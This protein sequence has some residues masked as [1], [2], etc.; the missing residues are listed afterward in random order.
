MNPALNQIMTSNPLAV[1]DDSPLSA[2]YHR[3]KREVVR[4]L[5]VVDWNG[6][7]VGIISDRDFQRA[8]WPV[9]TFS[10]I[11]L[12][13]GPLFKSYA[14]VS[15]Y[16]SWPVKSL[17]ENDDLL[18]AVRIMIDQKISA[19]IITRNQEMVGIVTYEDLLMVLAALIKEPPGL[20]DQALSIAYNSPIGRIAEFLSAAGI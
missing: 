8:I 1:R 17:D 10:E 20:K 2:A 5:P 11:G 12:P 14:V 9:T 7:V 4:H 6:H 19:V 13:D 3:M 18:K 16:M 15:D